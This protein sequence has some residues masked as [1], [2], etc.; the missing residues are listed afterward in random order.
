M[1]PLAFVLLSLSLPGTAGAA[2]KPIEA[3]LRP[4]GNKAVAVYKTTPQGDLKINLYFPPDWKA[5]DRRPA[6]VFFFGGSCARGSPAQFAPTAEYFAGRGLVA[7]APEYRIANIHHTPPERCIEDGKSAIRWLHMSAPHLGIDPGRIIA[8]GGSSGGTVAAFAAY[9]S[10]IEPEDEDRSASSRPDA[11]VLYNPALG[12]PD[13]RSRLTPEQRQAAQGPLGALIAGWKVT[14]GGPPAILFYG[15]EDPLQDKGGD[16]ARRLI[17]ART[18]AEMYTAAGQPHGFFNRFP[19]S[20]W[21]ALVL[22]QT[23]RFL[24]SLGYLRG[25]PTVTIP[26]DSTA[27]L[28]QAVP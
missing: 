16:F 21:H 1:R 18:R 9:N 22:R 15:T 3:D 14:G 26:P 20:P 2:L 17:A 11:L 8:G 10:T 23:D 12:F 19:D 28:E 4:I 5:S 25:A 6:I 7:A 13:D 27:V 24:A